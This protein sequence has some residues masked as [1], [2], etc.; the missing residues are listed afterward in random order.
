[1]IKSD[2]SDEPEITINGVRLSKGE[3]MTVRAAVEAFDST[4]SQWVDS[5]LAEES[6]VAKRY[7]VTLKGL[8]EIM[9]GGVRKF[10][11]CSHAAVCSLRTSMC[12]AGERLYN[13]YYYEPR[14]DDV[15]TLKPSREQQVTLDE[16]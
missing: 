13:C 5:P 1:M 2:M 14:T 11:P 15:E 12:I 9:Q 8:R 16:E 4:V 6:S 3:A 10:P 7:Y